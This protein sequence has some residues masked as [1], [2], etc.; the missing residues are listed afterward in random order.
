MPKCPERELHSVYTKFAYLLWVVLRHSYGRY[1][2][3]FS[4]ICN[5]MSIYDIFKICKK[6]QITKN[7]ILKRFFSHF[8]FHDKNF[9]TGYGA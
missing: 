3:S 7:L 6:T 1:E 5:Q 4:N 2:K 9:P 8:F